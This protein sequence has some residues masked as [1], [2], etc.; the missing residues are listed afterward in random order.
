MRPTASAQYL[1]DVD[2][3]VGQDQRQQQHH[4]FGVAVAVL[5]PRPVD[6]F[7]GEH[8][9]FVRGHLEHGRQA[10]QYAQAHTALFA[11]VFEQVEPDAGVHGIRRPTRLPGV[12]HT[13]HL[14][15][16]QLD[17]DVLTIDRDRRPWARADQRRPRAAGSV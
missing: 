11:V 3:V 9:E 10:R 7:G 4:V 16:I 2:A 13:H 8:E 14:Y 5:G 1:V 6:G 15:V 12:R 17:L